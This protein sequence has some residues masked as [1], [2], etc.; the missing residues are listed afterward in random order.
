VLPYYFASW[1]E[2]SVF[3]SA[4]SSYLFTAQRDRQLVA[5]FT[6][7]AYTI[8]VSN[9]PAGGGIVSGTGTNFYG[10]TNVLTVQPSFGYKFTNWTENGAVLGTNLILSTIVYSN[11]LIV[12]NYAEANLVHVV[13][14]ATAPGGIA[15]ISGAGSYTNGQTATFTAPATVLSPPYLYTFQK[16]TLSNNLVTSSTSFNKTFATTDQT[17]LQYVAVYNV[18]SIVPQVAAASA[19]YPSPVPATTNLVLT[20][21]FDRSM[22]PGVTPVVY[23]TNSA[24]TLQPTVPTQGYWTTYAVANDTYVTPGI[25]LV[26]GM[27]GTNQVFISGATDEREPDCRRDKS[28]R[29]TVSWRPAKARPSFAAVPVSKTYP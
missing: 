20:F 26:P 14:T 25:T 8:A 9:N 19:S 7:P 3:Q 6:L 21:R 12:A 10:T 15:T 24:T 13:T 29:P 16:F 18:M 22:Q 28:G 4:N 27:D 5:N 1:T 11:H 23:L 17:N 2:N